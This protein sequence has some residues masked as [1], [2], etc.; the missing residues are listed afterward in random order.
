VDDCLRNFVKKVW[1][2]KEGAHPSPPIARS[3]S[4]LVSNLGNEKTLNMEH[5]GSE[6][7]EIVVGPLC[8]RNSLERMPTSLNSGIEAS[9]SREEA[10]TTSHNF[11]SGRIATPLR[12]SRNRDRK[13]R[14][15]QVHTFM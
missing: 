14:S 7:I 5:K 2:R 4:L 1:Q 10:L 12:L 13:T 9:C 6:K 11:P 8:S 15:F 3:W